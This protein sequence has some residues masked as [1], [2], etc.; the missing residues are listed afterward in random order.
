M[1]F[2]TEEG[3][4]VT[5][6]QEAFSENTNKL[7]SL[8]KELGVKNVSFELK[9]NIELS[10]SLNLVSVLWTF[11]DSDNNEIYNATT[12][13]VMKN[14]DNGLKIK[15]VFVVDESSKFNKLRAQ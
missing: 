14:T 3:N 13:Y 12:R 9:S 1:T 10:A 8:Y 4:S 7:I 15:S 5:F 11:K 2:Y 6:E